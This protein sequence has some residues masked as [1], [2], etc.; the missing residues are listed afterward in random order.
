MVFKLY[1]INNKKDITLKNISFTDK[2]KIIDGILIIKSKLVNIDIFKDELSTDKN[3]LPMFDII[4][5]KFYLIH[6]DYILKSIKHNNMRVLNNDLI[7][8]FK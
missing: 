4:N 5:D 3:Y 6:K 8:F 1:D 7:T 2:Q